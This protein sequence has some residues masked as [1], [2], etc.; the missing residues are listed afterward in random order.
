MFSLLSS[1]PVTEQCKRRR[2]VK[3]TL[4]GSFLLAFLYKLRFVDVRDHTTPAL[5]SESNSSS[6]QT[7]SCKWHWM[8]NFLVK[9]L[10][11]FSHQLQCL[12][13]EV[14]QNHSTVHS[15]SG[16]L[17]IWPT[18]KYTAQLSMGKK[19]ALAFPLAL[20][21]FPPLCHPNAHCCSQ[22]YSLH[23]I[24]CIHSSPG[25]YSL[26]YHFLATVNSV[27]VKMDV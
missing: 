27:A 5:I 1:V 19:L 12:S 3:I 25:R 9:P 11:T 13:S 20:P 18:R 24:F 14:L 6:P 23:H 17:W 8:I 4:L 2:L 7:V 21:A 26:W 10:E 15:S 16:C 22:H